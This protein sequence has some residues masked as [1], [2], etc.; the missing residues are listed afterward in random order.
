MYKV[1]GKT[2]TRAMRV[3][4]AMHEIGLEFNHI[5]VAAQSVEAQKANISGKV[6]SL[7]LNDITITDSTAIIT[8]LADKYA[9]LTY[10]AGTIERAQQDSF[11][12]FILDEL[13]SIL[14]SA[15]RHSFVLP[16]ELEGK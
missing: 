6:P 11:T 4:W 7:I 9:Q 13:D 5:K 12:Q 2:N 8:Y 15:A 10:P 16:K 3:L 1:I 14:W